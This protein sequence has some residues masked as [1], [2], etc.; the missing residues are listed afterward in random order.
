MLADKKKVKILAKGNSQVQR[1]VRNKQKIGG[2]QAEGGGQVP[3]G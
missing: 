2:L 1:T 3:A